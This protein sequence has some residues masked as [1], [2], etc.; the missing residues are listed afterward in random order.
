MLA[1]LVDPRISRE[2]LVREVDSWKANSLHAERGWLLL[3]F[4]EDRLLVELA[5]LARLTISAGSAPLPVVACA[6]R[7]SYDNYDL[8][9]PS[10]T[11][12]DALTR[13]P[14][15]PPVRAF[16]PTPTGPLDVL[17][18]AHPATS[19]PFLCL[20][21]I[22]EYHT[23]PQH[24]GDDWLLHRELKEGSISTICDRVWRYMARN[25]IGL[26]VQ[27]Q[28]L[29]TWPLQAQLNISLGQGEIDKMFSPAIEAMP[30]SGVPPVPSFGD[31]ELA[32][33]DSVEST[34]LE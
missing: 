33:L 20:P 32:N 22:R 18:D 2:K 34:P 14:T 10:L 4:D 21:G 1:T 7:L 28:A 11:F 16:Q 15:K 25:I 8:W 9:A 6:I 3:S 19:R 12:I 5:F 26:T 17:I 24:T 31:H 23:H 27:I 30:D 13:Q 29:P